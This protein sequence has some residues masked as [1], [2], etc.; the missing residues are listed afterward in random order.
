MIAQATPAPRP[1]AVPRTPS[2][3]GNKVPLPH[4]FHL[5]D[6]R[7]IGGHLHKAPNTRLTDH[8]SMLKGFI[9][10]TNARCERT[11]ATFPFLAL[12]QDHVLFVEELASGEPPAR[13]VALGAFPGGSR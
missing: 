9:C 11:G 7:I 5:T 1:Q 3:V 4:R 12:N 13:S 10:V 8:L 6:G 2:M